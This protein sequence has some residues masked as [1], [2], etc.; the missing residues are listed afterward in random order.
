MRRIKRE[1]TQRVSWCDRPIDGF[2]KSKT[3]RPSC[4]LME[5]T[6]VCITDVF[7]NHSTMSAS[8]AWSLSIVTCA[9]P[10]EPRLTQFA[11]ERKRKII[12]SE[13]VVYLTP[14]EIQ[15]FC[16]IQLKSRGADATGSTPFA[17]SHPDGVS[18][19]GVPIAHL[20]P[21]AQSNV[22][23]VFLIFKIPFYSFYSF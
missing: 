3:Q 17:F 15:W 1:M 21:L 9:K 10:N 6:V 4:R 22:H 14:P 5:K 23:L 13:C 18:A 20:A 16:R 7:D 11:F 19:P 2:S 12:G 8:S